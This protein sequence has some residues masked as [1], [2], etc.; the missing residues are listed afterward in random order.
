MYWWILGGDG[1]MGVCVCGGELGQDMRASLVS[2]IR[3]FLVFFIW[4]TTQNFDL[5]TQNVD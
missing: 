2:Y 4:L 5:L 1:A 3:N